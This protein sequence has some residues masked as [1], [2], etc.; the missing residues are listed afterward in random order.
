MKNIIILLFITLLIGF[1]FCKQDMD[2]SQ[3]AGKLVSFDPSKS[4]PEAIRVADDLMRAC[5]GLEAWDNINV[6]KYNYFGRRWHLW[7]K[8]NQ[9][10]RIENT[11]ND[12][13][14]ILDLKAMKA[15]LYKDGKEWTDKDTLKK[16]CDM[17]YRQWINDSYWLMMP[18][19]VKDGGVK[20]KYLREDTTQTGI[21]SDVIEMQFD[22]VG[23]TPQNK[24]ELWVG[25][26]S[27]LLAQWAYFPK[28]SDT[29]AAFINPWDGYVKYGDAFISSDRGNNRQFSGIKVF[30]EVPPSVFK[31]FE[32]VDF[33]KM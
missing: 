14:M 9:M 24:Y 5:G 17:A 31:T 16:Y 6:I 22:S 21:M 26:N 15:K 23:V 8:K 11:A 32:K 27:G 28:A 30:N 12:T 29:A 19:K 25:K 4:D 10:I 33:E 18:F 13:K 20:L 1:S 2:T 7:D 3:A